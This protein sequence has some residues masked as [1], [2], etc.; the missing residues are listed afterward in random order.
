MLDSVQCSNS[1]ISH[2]A[3]TVLHLHWHDMYSTITQQERNNI[4]LNIAIQTER[5]SKEPV[6][7]I[8]QPVS[9]APTGKKYT[10]LQI[11]STTARDASTYI[12]YIYIADAYVWCSTIG[13][14]VCMHRLLENV[15]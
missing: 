14:S 8:H 3:R 7:S 6:L 11:P 5:L 2:G 1:R 13:R 15:C 10:I 9:T 4:K 12:L